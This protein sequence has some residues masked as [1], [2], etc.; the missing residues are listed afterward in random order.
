VR[1]W[2]PGSVEMDGI[3]CPSRASAWRAVY[4]ERASGRRLRRTFLERVDLSE[5]LGKR[6]SPN[7]FS[8]HPSGWVL[9]S[10]GGKTMSAEITSPESFL[11]LGV[12]AKVLTTAGNSGGGGSF[13]VGRAGNRRAWCLFSG[14]GLVCEAHAEGFVCEARART[15][16]L[17]LSL[18]LS[19]THMYISRMDTCI[20]THKHTQYIIICI[21]VYKFHIY[22]LAYTC[23]HV[24]LCMTHTHTHA[25]IC[26]HILTLHTAIHTTIFD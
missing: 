1:R 2:G 5:A 26:T 6:M 15:F 22:P 11:S 21:C 12:D 8:L 18:S 16:S 4:L 3:A 14:L 20:H 7:A 24:C 19:H 25:C 10:L 23:M 13:L 9:Y 17:S